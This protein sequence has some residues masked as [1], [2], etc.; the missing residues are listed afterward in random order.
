[1]TVSSRSSV[2]FLHIRVAVDLAEF[3]SDVPIDRAHFV[4]GSVL[5]HF[6]EVCMPASLEHAAILA[7]ERGRDEAAG[8]QFQP[9]DLF[10][11]GVSGF[12]PRQSR[13]GQPGKN[14][15][16]DLLARLLLGLRFVAHD[17]AVAQDIGANRFDILRGDIAATAP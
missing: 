16:D 15:F 14:C 10:E 7:G 1:M 13:H 12:H 6:L 5:A 9:A 2:N 8:L 4:A 3:R 11:N 17:N